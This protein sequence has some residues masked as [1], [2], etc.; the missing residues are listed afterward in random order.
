MNLISLFD[1]MGGFPLA[2]C[3]VTGQVPAELRYW[4]SE[5][6][7]WPMAVVRRRFPNVVE[8][9]SVTDVDI[10]G[11]GF[12]GM[13]C[14]S[15]SSND[16]MPR[17]KAATDADSIV[18]FGSPCQDLSV[19]GK[20][21]GL[22]GERSGLFHAAIDIVRDVRPKYC[23]W[24]NVAGAFSSNG[25]ADFAIV[26]REFADI[27]YD[28]VWTLI[29]AQWCGVPQRRRRVFLV[30]VRDGVPAGTDLFAFGRRTPDGCASQIQSIT[31]SRSGNTAQGRETGQSI[32]GTIGACAGDGRGFRQDLDT[33]GAY[34]P[35]VSATLQSHNGGANEPVR[36]GAIIPAV[37]AP[38]EF[39]GEVR[40]ANI[41][42]ALCTGGGKPGLGYPC[43][44]EGTTVRRLTPTECLRLQGFPDDWF[45]GVDKYS[46]TKAYKAIGNSVAIPAVEWVLRCVLDFD[47][48]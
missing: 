21:A 41:H 38:R 11:F 34:V 2:W 7:P 5:I 6:E 25:G 19:A 13:G 48:Q 22:S 14:N 39:A 12:R 9:G 31:E 36:F 28:A 27:G 30:G 15:R 18:T 17:G 44:R 4:S 23:V 47:R 3:N 16:T 40:E 8:L 42:G 33:C 1:G 45:A 26:L 46:D 43:I 37:M 35:A 29:D 32:A 10:S 20:R 24:E